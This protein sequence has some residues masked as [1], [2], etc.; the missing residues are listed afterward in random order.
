[1][2][3]APRPRELPTVYRMGFDA[4]GAGRPLAA[5]LKECAASKKYR[6]GEW[7]VLA[8]GARLLSSLILYRLPPEPAGAAAGLGSI[9]T[10]PEQR[11]RGRA[12]RLIADVL[13]EL[14]AEGVAV[15]YLHSEIGGRYYR[16]F[17]FRPLPARLQRRADSVCMSRG[18]PRRFPAAYRAPDY[19]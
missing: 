9:A 5:Y 2:V 14:D 4:W 13:R 7:R 8:D 11:R 19:F 12:A 3:R 17:G 6:G 10:P 1:M 18:G 16:R 15:V